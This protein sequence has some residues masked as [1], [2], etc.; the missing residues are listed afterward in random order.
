M[1]STRKQVAFISLVAMLAVLPIL[2]GCAGGTPSSGV[3][4]IAVEGGR[5][6]DVMPDTLTDMLSDKKFVLVNVHTPY[7]GEIAKTDQ[8]LPY[9]QIGQRLSS[10]P[11]KKSRI[12]LYC[13]SGHMSALAAQTLVKLGYTDVW[14]LHG[15]MDLWREYGYPLLE[16]T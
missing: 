12:I 2:A 16:N 8:F 3:K 9:D 14:N 1:S 15:G 4:T 6:I 13:A 5:F 10:L 11:D 7:Q